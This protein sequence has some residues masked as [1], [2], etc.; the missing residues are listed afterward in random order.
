MKNFKI[1]N[2]QKM[3]VNT[4]Q[5]YK[6]HTG[7]P[8]IEAIYKMKG[9]IHLGKTFENLSENE[10]RNQIILNIISSLTSESCKIILVCNFI[11]HLKY[12]SER[13]EN[14]QIVYQFLDDYSKDLNTIINND[15]TIIT[16]RVFE[17]ILRNIDKD[18]LFFK[19]KYNIIFTMTRRIVNPNII[20][21][22][23]TFHEICDEDLWLRKFLRE[24]IKTY[25]SLG[26][27]EEINEDDDENE[28]TIKIEILNTV[29]V[30][31]SEE[32]LKNYIQSIKV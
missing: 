11:K 16:V 21:F 24:K 28:G 4:L 6:I 1:F 30:N 27:K 2:N 13:L 29:Y 8:S 9:L 15:I 22:K 25:K 12:F 10:E 5:S 3:D 19:E 7:I 14:S 20:N 32:K 26:F 23:G 31:F 18:H 17:S